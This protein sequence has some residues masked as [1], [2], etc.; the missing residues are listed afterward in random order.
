MSFVHFRLCCSIF[1]VR[2]CPTAAYLLYPKLFHLSST[3]FNFLKKFF[4]TASGFGHLLS[5]GG[6]SF[7]QI[8]LPLS[9]CFLEFSLFFYFRQNKPDSLPFKLCKLTRKQ[10]KLGR[11]LRLRLPKGRWDRPDTSG[12]REKRN[13]RNPYIWQRFRGLGSG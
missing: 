1:K 8:F 13:T 11:W 10:A 5:G 2:C 6:F 9:I 7:Y 4:S 3:F 12:R